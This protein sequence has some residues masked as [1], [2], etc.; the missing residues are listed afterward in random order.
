MFAVKW[1]SP[2]YWPSLFLQRKLFRLF[3]LFTYSYIHALKGQF[4]E[5]KNILIQL[6]SFL[7]SLFLLFYYAFHI[8]TGL[9]K[10]ILSSPTSS[11]SH[12]AHDALAINILTLVASEVGVPK[13]K[14]LACRGLRCWKA[15]EWSV[16]V[17]WTRVLECRRL[18]CWCAV[19]WGVGVLRIEV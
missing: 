5:E 4:H 17:P 15:T 11:S 2:F 6:V 16:G 12:T 19:D 13:T 10:Q 18:K 7:G 8:N 9:I 14:V 1:A 3:W